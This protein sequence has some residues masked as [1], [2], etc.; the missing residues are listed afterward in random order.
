[1]SHVGLNR[2]S[3]ATSLEVWPYDASEL[4]EAI[5]RNRGWVLAQVIH[6]WDGE[7]PDGVWPV[8]VWEFAGGGVL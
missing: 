1:V 8:L 7:R 6:P 5:A 2:Q 4:N 3:R